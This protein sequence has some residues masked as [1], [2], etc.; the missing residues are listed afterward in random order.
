MHPSFQSLVPPR[1]SS[2]SWRMIRHVA[3]LTNNLST[4]DEVVSSAVEGAEIL[5][6]HPDQ[7]AAL[8]ARFRGVPPFTECAGLALDYDAWAAKF[9]HFAERRS[10]SSQEPLT[11]AV[12]VALCGGDD[13]YGAHAGPHAT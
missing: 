10:R 6:T 4:P 9:T 5:V 3:D 11:Q 13:E 8:D 12:A 2:G 7:T 1:G